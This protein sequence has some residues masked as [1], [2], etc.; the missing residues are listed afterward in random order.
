M[1]VI[2]CAVS[3]VVH[4]HTGQSVNFD[5][6]WTDVDA[7]SL[8]FGVK[9]CEEAWVAFTGTLNSVYNSSYFVMIGTEGNTKTNLKNALIGSVIKEV[10]TADILSCVETRYFWAAWSAGSFMF[11][12]GHMI[13]EHVVLDEVLPE[14][15]SVRA[16]TVS[17]QN[18]EG[19]WEFTEMS[20]WCTQRLMYQ[21]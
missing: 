9:A 19:R 8:V 2:S 11:G 20:G 18:A 7:S 17:T 12:Q 5:Q 4:A 13:G 14:P 6:A 21:T 15:V 3:P 16:M 10:D 1:C